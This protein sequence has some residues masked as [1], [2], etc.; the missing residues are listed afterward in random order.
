MRPR[1][2]FACFVL[3]K[4]RLRTSGERT[5]FRG[6]V[7]MEVLSLEPGAVTWWSLDYQVLA[8]LE[9]EGERSL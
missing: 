2:V 9:D 3:F 4:M 1:E 5:Q 8:S 7:D 6:G